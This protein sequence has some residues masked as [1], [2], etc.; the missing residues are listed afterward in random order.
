MTAIS[1]TTGTWSEQNARGRAFARGLIN[2]M[3]EE[4]DAMV[5][6]AELRARFQAGQCSGEDIGFIFA[7]SAAIMSEQ[8]SAKPSSDQGSSTTVSERD[9]IFG[10]EPG[11]PM[12]RALT[13][14]E[15]ATLDRPSRHIR[16]PEV[17][18]LVGRSRPTIYRLIKEGRF[19]KPVHIGRTSSWVLGEIKEYLATVGRKT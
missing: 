1:S 19:P 18:L 2:Q 10:A 16:M 3:I 11:T 6:A 8:V 13:P 14:T 5:L 15:V 9:R 12:K 17:C 7:L 4:N